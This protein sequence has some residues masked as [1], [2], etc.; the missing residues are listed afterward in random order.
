MTEAL[1]SLLIV[2]DEQAERARLERA[3]LRAELGCIIHKAST[4]SAAAIAFRR[5]RPEVVILDLGLSG[6]G[7]QAGLQLIARFSA[8]DPSSRIIVLTGHTSEEIGVEAIKQGAASFLTKP[9]PMLALLALIKD[10]SQTAKFRRSVLSAQQKDSVS[11]Y[12]GLIGN[13]PAMRNVYRLL[14]HCAAN[15]ANVLIVGETGTGKELVAQAIHQL[16]IRRQ[17]P[18]SVYFGSSP[19]S[20]AEAELFGYIHGAFTGA[21][22]EGKIGS[23]KQADKGSL[24]IDE[25][26]SLDL[27]I[28]RKL[29]RAVETKTFKPLG[30]DNYVSSDFRLICAA[31]PRVYDLVRTGQFREDLLSRVEVVTIQLPPL[32]ERREDILLLAEHFQ[33]LAREELL[34]SGVSCH[35]WG[36]SKAAKRAFLEYHWPRNVRQLKNAVQNGLVQAQL[37]GSEQIDLEDILARLDPTDSRLQDAKAAIDS[38][39]TVTP[40]KEAVTKLEK[41]LIVES[42]KRNNGMLSVVSQELGLGRTTLWRKLKEYQLELPKL[43]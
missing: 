19:A 12:P 17:F 38:S 22:R 15:T 11:R 31:Q 1:F 25:L 21:T 26:C 13:A 42:L 7:P 6:Q 10:Y 34:E 2:E 35:V 29:L 4:P 32:R 20:M 28:Q 37:R 41:Q 39:L 43:S 16:S 30:S 36:F 27:D 8:L 5:H 24:F 9:A 23:L 18:F 14:E 33:K 40:I 3:L